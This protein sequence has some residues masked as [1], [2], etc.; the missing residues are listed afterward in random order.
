M[1]KAG[2]L[3]SLFGLVAG[4]ANASSI[5]IIDSGTDLLHKDLANKNW[6]NKGEIKNNNVDDENNGY[7]DDYNGW[8]FAENNSKVIDYKHLGTFSAEVY[9]FF[10]VQG[11]VLTGTATE[12]EK[13]WMR[14]KRGD[15]EFIKELMRFG[16][17]VHGTHVA[18][19]SARSADHTRVMPIKIIPTEQGAPASVR[20][21]Q[22]HNYFKT[23]TDFAENP[24][25]LMALNMLASQQSGLFE[26]IGDYVA[27]A[28]SSVANGSFG[29]SKAAVKP[30]IAS[31]VS[32]ITGEEPTEADV[33]SY[34]NYFLT[35][36]VEGATKMPQK[37]PHTL[38][39]FAAGNDGTNNDVDPV[40][41]AN[42]K[43]PNTLTVAATFENG[44]L[45]PFSNTGAK[46]V[47]VAAPGVVIESPIP[48]NEYIKMS[49]TSQAAPYVTNVAALIQDANPSLN[50]MD[51][52]RIIIETVDYKAHLAGKVTSGGLV[53]RDRAVYAAQRTTS[54]PVSQAISESRS[55]VP[56]K[57]ILRP[58]RHVDRSA[59]FVLPLPNTMGLR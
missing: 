46:M 29:T 2:M 52:R 26:K 4:I 47:E 37:S 25:V 58:A 56:D 24:I 38:F 11:K 30:L 36:V 51:V 34:S 17:F 6:V 1:K 3:V 5:A 20:A 59:L 33:D 16:N 23:V 53:N 10:D 41:P 12:E 39:V 15:E 9:K 50:V 40:S 14:S 32:M 44:Q 18:G 31:L 43:L 13:T 54:V 42:V 21:A 45:A 28:R 19:I 57:V 35:Q 48:G 22:F 49:G 55:Q 7:V 27:F 8:N